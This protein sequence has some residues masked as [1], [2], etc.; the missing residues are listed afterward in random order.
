M[1]NIL[2]T[3]KIDHWDVG[4]GQQKAFHCTDEDLTR[5]PSV[6][7]EIGGIN[8]SIPPQSYIKKYGNHCT[9]AEMSSQNYKDQIS[10]GLNFME[11]YYT[12]FDIDNRRIGLMDS[13]NSKNL[14]YNSQLY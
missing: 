5:L 2:S 9:I 1:K 7:L 10:L 12:I 11:N 13:I 6:N 14:E 3:Q 4:V 8:Y